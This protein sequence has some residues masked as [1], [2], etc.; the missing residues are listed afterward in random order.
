MNDSFSLKWSPWEMLPITW[1]L[2]FSSQQTTDSSLVLQSHTYFSYRTN[3]NTKWFHL[4]SVPRALGRGEGKLQHLEHQHGWTVLP[5]A[6]WEVLSSD[7]HLARWLRPTFPTS[8]LFQG[9]ETLISHVHPRGSQRPNEPT[10]RG[11]LSVCE[12]VCVPLFLSF[13][14]GQIIS[15]L[16]CENQEIPSKILLRLNLNTTLKNA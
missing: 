10:V 12:C 4:V 11:G 13:N 8:R 9:T 6:C 14:L 3:N 16:M 7:M 5:T 2:I 15:S 1:C